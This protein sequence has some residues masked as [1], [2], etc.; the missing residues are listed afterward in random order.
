MRA[1][2]RLEPPVNIVNSLRERCYLAGELLF[3]PLIELVLHK[4]RRPAA[5]A[6]QCGPRSGTFALPR[7]L[8]ALISSWPRA[9][10]SD[11]LTLIGSYARAR[12]M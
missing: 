6:Q 7:I 1:W 5:L 11:P 2:T 4:L 12:F 10:A 3:I 9:F 8:P